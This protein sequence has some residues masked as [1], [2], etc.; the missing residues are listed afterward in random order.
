[1]N[2]CWICFKIIN[3]NEE[4]VEGKYKKIPILHMSENDDK[5]CGYLSVILPEP[6]HYKCMRYVMDKIVEATKEK[7]NA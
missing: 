3:N 4:K 6:M 1:M 5:Y 7:R 2:K